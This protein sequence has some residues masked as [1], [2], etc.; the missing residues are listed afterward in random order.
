VLA[1]RD[2]ETPDVPEA[3]GHTNGEVKRNAIT[4]DECGV[5]GVSSPALL[6]APPFDTTALSEVEP[7]PVEWL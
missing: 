4:E 1:V 2:R 7:K 5:D 6:P 3:A